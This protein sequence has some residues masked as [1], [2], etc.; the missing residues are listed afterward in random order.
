MI[1]LKNSTI[2]QSVHRELR[3][4]DFL[5]SSHITTSH[6]KV[7]S[8]FLSFCGFF[9][10]LFLFSLDAEFSHNLIHPSKECF[11]FFLFL[12]FC[13][14]FLRRDGVLFRAWP[15]QNYCKSRLKGTPVSGC[16]ECLSLPLASAGG[17][18]NLQ[19]N[20]GF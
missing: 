6:L 2:L 19:P 16:T 7:P 3:C 12:T 9:V 14:I 18:D 15:Q 4:W 17:K 10:F 8:S 20:I 1:L 13:N 11:F 5:L